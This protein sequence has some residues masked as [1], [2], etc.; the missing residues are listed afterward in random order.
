MRLRG[1]QE[2]S[3]LKRKFWRSKIL[4]IVL[5]SLIILI[6]YPLA[7]KNNQRRA[8][9]KEIKELQA[10]ADRITD[11]N[12]DLRDLINYLEGDGFAEKEARV[13]LDLKKPGEKVAVI[14]DYNAA[15]KMATS[16]AF[17]IPGLDKAAAVPVAGNPQKWRK[18]FFANYQ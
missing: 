16:S 1:M 6:A 8:L 13:S 11:K 7:K 14:K 4:A 15:E 10:E 3:I 9:D 2:E 18:Y 5:L 17:N 12:K